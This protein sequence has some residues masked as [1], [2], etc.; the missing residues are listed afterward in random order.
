MKHLLFIFLF[1]VIGISVKAQTPTVGL[2][3]HTSGSN[4]NGYVLFSPMQAPGTFL[5]DKCGNL[6][7]KWTTSYLPGLAGYLLPDGTLLKAGKYTNPVFPGITGGIIQTYDWNSTLLW[8]FVFSD[9]IQSQAHD[10]TYMPNGNIL[11]VVWE[12]I[13]LS[14]AIANGRDSSNVTG[15]S[16]YCPKIVEIQPS[17][18]SANIVWQWRLMDHLIQDF[19]SAKPNYGVVANHPELVN[20]NFVP[21]PTDDWIHF[22]EVNYNPVLN[23]LVL[24]AHNLSEIWIIDHSTTKAEAAQHTGG[25]HNK[26]GDLLYR[27]GNPQAYNR[28]TATDQRLFYVHN[29]NWIQSG[30]RFQNQLMMFNNGTN[31]PS[32]NLSSVDIV[33]PPVDSSGNYFLASGA[34]FGPDSAVWSYM[35][36]NFYSNNLGSTQMLDNGNVSIC[37]GGSGVLFEIDSLKNMVWDYVNPVGNTGPVSQGTTAVNNQL[38]KCIF[39]PSNYSG[40]A[41][42]SITAGAPIEHNPYPSTCSIITTQVDNTISESTISIFPNPSSSIFTIDSNY[43]QQTST[44]DQIII[45]NS[46]G[47]VVYQTTINSKQSIINLSSQPNG[48]YFIKLKTAK[49]IYIKKLVLQN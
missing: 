24:G 31:R 48:I 37:E 38:Y 6:I 44:N 2:I 25:L 7:H 30:Y 23:Q 36:P 8:S 3:Q 12:N 47:E 10:I 5:I 4:D 20:F 9:S 1:A 22:N 34:A 33:I 18:T 19:D 26:G 42:H 46:I 39:Y 17:G 32:G 29:P 28:G 21:L 35:S 15:S 49:N 43:N 13:L 14:E 45:T 16:I 41:G 40:F 11:L 27:W